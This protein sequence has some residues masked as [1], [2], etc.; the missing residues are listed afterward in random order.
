MNK[1]ETYIMVWINETEKWHHFKENF[2]PEVFKDGYVAYEID[3]KD[4]L[5]VA[6]EW[7]TSNI[8][9]SFKA[10]YDAALWNAA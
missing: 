9:K 3:V 7:K 6:D 2:D 4:D 1:K 8:G 10:C 5:I